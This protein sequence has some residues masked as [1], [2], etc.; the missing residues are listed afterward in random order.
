[1]EPEDRRGGAL[2]C[3]ADIYLV[4]SKNTNVLALS[5]FGAKVASALDR[6]NI[7]V[8]HEISETPDG[9][10]SLVMAQVVGHDRVGVAVNG[11]DGREVASNVFSRGDA[12]RDIIAVSRAAK[13][14]LGEGAGDAGRP[15]GQIVNIGDPIPVNDCGNFEFFG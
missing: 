14:G 9:Q 3:E 11:D 1:M 12:L 5:R 15:V 7:C 2:D 4:W 6:P 10:L 13:P 8:I